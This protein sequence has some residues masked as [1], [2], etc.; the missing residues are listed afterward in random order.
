MFFS[1]L[2]RADGGAG[3]RQKVS[4]R[5]DLDLSG[6]VTCDVYAPSRRAKSART[7]V[8]VHGVTF[9]GC[10]DSRLVH[11][12]RCLARSN[13]TC[14][15]PSLPCLSAGD[16]DPADIGRLE[17]AIEY[18]SER[19]DSPLGLVGFSFGASYALVAACRP[20]IAAKLRYLLSIGAYYSLGDV[21]ARYV[22][23]S[24]SAARSDEDWDNYIYLHVVMAHQHPDFLGQSGVARGAVQDLF[25][26]YCHHSSIA[27][28]LMQR[29]ANSIPTVVRR[30]QRR[31]HGVIPLSFS[32]SAITRS[33]YPFSIR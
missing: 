22:D 11:F 14:V 7:M 33:M 19:Y 26:R 3:P 15:V 31:R 9:A 28:S 32:V 1:R 17:A 6:R 2:A 21:F 8:A 4:E 24:E 23:A 16:F 18:A 10:K 25:Q 20:A 30:N 27:G 13:V 5:L 12:A 29:S